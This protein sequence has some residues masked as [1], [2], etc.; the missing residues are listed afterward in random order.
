VLRFALVIVWLIVV[1][2]ALCLHHAWQR[3]RAHFDDL[4]AQCQPI[5]GAARVGW[6]NMS[7]PLAIILVTDTTLFVGGRWRYLPGFAAAVTP[8][9]VERIEYM[10]G[11]TG[12]RLNIVRRD[13]K[14]LWFMG[15]DLTDLLREHGW[16]VEPSA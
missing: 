12:K 15:P 13:G 3:D 7:V 2:G 10:T 16:R 5:V 14:R 9:E 8:D 6:W 4:R 1:W 11:L